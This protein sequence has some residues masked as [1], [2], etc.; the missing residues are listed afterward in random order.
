MKIKYTAQAIKPAY[1]SIEDI[2]SGKET[3]T[4]VRA[5]DGDYWASQ[6]YAVIGVAE[7]TVSLHSNDKIVADQI[8]A[9]QK[10]LHT[11]RAEHQCAQNAIIDQISKLQAI[12]NAA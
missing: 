2:A 6:G 4:I 1:T 8:A 11:V 7:I 5:G 10:K 12:T 3:P 9:L